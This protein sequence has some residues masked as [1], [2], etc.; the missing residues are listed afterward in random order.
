[1]IQDFFNKTFKKLSLTQTKDGAGGFTNVYNEISSSDFEASIKLANANDIKA[2][3]RE[4]YN[5]THILHCPYTIDIKRGDR[6]REVATSTD[7][8]VKWIREVWGHH[9]KVFLEKIE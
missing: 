7:Y 4:K 9:K 3:A 1:M 6:I 5:A 8:E 2:D